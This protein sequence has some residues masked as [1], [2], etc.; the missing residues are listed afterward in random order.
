[1]Y[2]PF[3][4]GKIAF[5]AWGVILEKYHYSIPIRNERVS[6]DE[7]GHGIVQGDFYFST[8]LQIV[9]NR[10]FPDTVFRI[11]CK[12]ASGDADAARFT[13]TPGY[14]FDFSFSKRYKSG[15]SGTFLPFGSLGFYSWQSYNE[16][17]P[18]NDA[19][20]YGTGLQYQNEK[21]LFSGSFS[22]YSGYL[23]IRDK[24]QL[25]TFESRYDWLKTAVR[26]QFLSG[27]RH[28]NYQTVRFSFIWK[29]KSS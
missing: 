27:T 12:T 28:W 18:Q 17:T 21:W 9:K 22:G 6:R 25:L 29:L 20:L 1:L 24:P 3:A 7:D 16:A 2:V 5:E 10:K 15:K 4:G 14:F 13:D 23:Q 11:A 8:M 19:L 26:F